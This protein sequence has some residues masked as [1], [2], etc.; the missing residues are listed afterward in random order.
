MRINRQQ[1]TENAQN[2]SWIT[3]RREY[4]NHLF[5]CQKGPVTESPKIFFQY[6]SFPFFFFSLDFSATKR[7]Q[8]IDTM[9]DCKYKSHT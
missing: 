2:K 3:H 5:G 6:F 1:K 7:Y 9:L 4:P 8:D